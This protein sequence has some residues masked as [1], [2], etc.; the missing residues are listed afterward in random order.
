VSDPSPDDLLLEFLDGLPAM[1]RHDLRDAIALAFERR[2]RHFDESVLAEIV[3]EIVRPRENWLV[4]QRVVLVAGLLD[5]LM[6][7][8][9]FETPTEYWLNEPIR[10]DRSEIAPISR[11]HYRKAQARWYELRAGPLSPEALFQS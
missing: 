10:N 8:I 4:R 6:D 5:H 3:R 2:P 1:I 7:T 11:L 9:P